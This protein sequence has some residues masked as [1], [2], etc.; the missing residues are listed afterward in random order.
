[1]QKASA[2]TIYVCQ[3]CG[4]VSAKW[5]GRCSACGEWNSLSEEKQVLS[6]VPAKGR[7]KE[8]DTQVYRLSEIQGDPS[9]RITTG[10][11]EFDR[12]LGGGIVPGS[13]ILVSGDPGIGK[14]TLL[15]QLCGH[16]AQSGHKSLY[17]TGEESQMQIKI[18]A[19]RLD[20]NSE[21]IAIACL[22]NTDEIINALNQSD[23]GFLIIDSIQTLR[24]PEFE[25]SAGTVTQI[26]ESVSTLLDVCQIKGITSFL[27]GHVTKEGMIAGPKVLEHLVDVVL[28]FE[29]EKSHLF[30]VLRAEKNRYGPTNESGIYSIES[31]GLKAVVNPSLA[32]I[33]SRRDNE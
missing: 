1:M 24:S 28:Y 10:E 5:A 2:K 21:L 4:A 20:I 13:S 3:A 25:S 8:H 33:S 14:S 7:G 16:L 17:V 30:R 19:E 18:R 32:F 31:S 23:Y 27:I 11:A 6:R 22:T 12:A 9:F 26:R 15:L 29:G